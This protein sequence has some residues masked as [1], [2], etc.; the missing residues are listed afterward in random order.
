MAC[1][2]K[3]PLCVSVYVCVCVCMKRHAC[4]KL[5]IIDLP[6]WVFG[7]NYEFIHENFKNRNNNNK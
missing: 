4:A 3:S 6:Q 7:L 5:R 1:R 2:L